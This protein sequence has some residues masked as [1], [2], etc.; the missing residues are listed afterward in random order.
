[1]REG[2]EVK[3][4]PQDQELYVLAAGDE[5]SGSARARREEHNPIR[6]GLSHRTVSLPANPLTLTRAC[7]GNKR[8][9]R[10]EPE[11]RGGNP[12][13]RA[14]A[15]DERQ[16]T[17]YAAAALLPEMLLCVSMRL[18]SVTPFVSEGI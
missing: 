10:R 15:S 4:L 6:Q 2:V 12:E 18:S 13:L 17:A 16:P 7:E 3:L 5:A 8:A 1:V 14:S 9:R 11:K